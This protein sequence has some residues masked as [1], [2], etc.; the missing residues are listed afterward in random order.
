[1][2]IR[3]RVLY[4]HMYN[5]SFTTKDPTD[6]YIFVVSL[7]IKV[8]GNVVGKSQCNVCSIS[9][10]THSTERCCQMIMYGKLW[11][12]KYYSG[13]TY[14]LCVLSGSFHRHEG[15]NKVIYLYS[16]Y[17]SQIFFI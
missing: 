5:T 12:A 10:I 7:I 11:Y 1:M 14:L 15:K 9:Y 3:K 6:F 4:V 2:G 13:T 17:A 16:I 8:V